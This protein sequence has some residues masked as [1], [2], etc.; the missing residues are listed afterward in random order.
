MTTE[1]K[2][3]LLNDI[4]SIMKLNQDEIDSITSGYIQT[5]PNGEHQLVLLFGY[6]EKKN[7]KN[8]KLRLYDEEEALEVYQALAHFISTR[9]GKTRP[10]LSKSKPSSTNH[11]GSEQTNTKAQN[12]TEDIFGNE[13]TENNDSD[14]FK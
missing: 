3:N 11:F 9:I 10:R 5:M 2:V 14:P 7:S 1:E 12:I 8:K 6:D 4:A 13:Y